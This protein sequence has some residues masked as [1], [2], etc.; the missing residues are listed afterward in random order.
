MLRICITDNEFRANLVLRQPEPPKIS[1]LSGSPKIETSNRRT[2]LTK[3]LGS[4]PTSSPG[5]SYP[6]PEGITSPTRVAPEAM[7][8]FKKFLGL[9]KPT[10]P[11]TLKPSDNSSPPMFKSKANKK[12]SSFFGERPPDELIVD[13]LEQFFPNIN[14]NDMVSP[15]QNDQLK[16]I[17]AANIKKKRN[18]NR[19]SSMMLR[20]QSGRLSGIAVKRITPIIPED[21]VVDEEPAVIQEKVVE[22]PVAPIRW[23]AGQLIGQGAFGKVF[24]ALNLDNGEFMAVKQILGGDDS[25]IK[26]SIESLQREIELLKELDHDNIVRYLGYEN[27]DNTF[28][29]FLEYIS[30]GSISSCLVKCGKFPENI[31]RSFAAQILCGLEY[32]H[33]RNIIHRDIKGANILITGDGAVKITDFGISKKNGKIH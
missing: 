26:K 5:R 10:S 25:Q 2:K 23:T 33:D 7:S 8:D 19:M 24:H 9:D 11:R 6:G 1:P 15:K 14:I 32:L 13:Q 17:V 29:V 31:A 3:L 22:S 20:R 21:V 16:S 4:D 28:N 12:L 18:S 30:G 27:K